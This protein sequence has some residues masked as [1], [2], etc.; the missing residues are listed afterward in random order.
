M[1]VHQKL[2]YTAEF[3]GPKGEVNPMGLKVPGR[4]PVQVFPIRCDKW[5]IHN[6]KSKGQFS[7]QSF[8]TPDKAINYTRECLFEKQETEWDITH[9]DGKPVAVTDQTTTVIR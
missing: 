4:I 3:S 2:L 1:S 6:P 9:M 5:I 8:D 7:K